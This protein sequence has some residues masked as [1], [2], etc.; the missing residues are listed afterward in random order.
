MSHVK[1]SGSEYNRDVMEIIED[2]NNAQEIVEVLSYD[3]DIELIRSTI[4]GLIE[5]IINQV[6]SEMPDSLD[7][8]QSMP[9]SMPQG[10]KDAQKINTE[11]DFWFDYM[12]QHQML[13]HLNALLHSPSKFQEFLQTNPEVLDISVAKKS[14]VKKDDKTLKDEDAVQLHF[15][16]PKIIITHHKENIKKIVRAV[17]EKLQLLLNNS[18]KEGLSLLMFGKVQQQKGLAGRNNILIKEGAED[19]LQVYV[20]ERVHTFLNQMIFKKLP[21]Y[22]KPLTEG[23]CNYLSVYLLETI[24]F[25]KS[26]SS[27]GNLDKDL[28]SIQEGEQKEDKEHNEKLLKMIIDKIDPQKKEGDR[29]ILDIRQKI[30]NDSDMSSLLLTKMQ[31]KNIDNVTALKELWDEID[32]NK[33]ELSYNIRALKELWDETDNNK[34]K[35]NANIEDLKKIWKKID[36]NKKEPNEHNESL[37]E[38]EAVIDISKKKLN[39]NIDDLKEEFFTIDEATM[40]E[41]HKLSLYDYEFGQTLV[42]VFIDQYPSLIEAMPKF[43]E[44]YCMFYSP[45]YTRYGTIEKF[46]KGM[47]KLGYSNAFINKILTSTADR[48]LLKSLKGER[49]MDYFMKFDL[50]EL[51][52]ILQNQELHVVF[53]ISKNDTILLERNISLMNNYLKRHYSKYSHRQ[54]IKQYFQEKLINQLKYL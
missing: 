21:F 13:K 40:K 37:K 53:G 51:K 26:Q 52:I 5:D 27:P 30:A 35:I 17:D 9:Q 47:S 24:V 15:I 43:L 16:L 32:D 7:E 12:D 54:Y 34:K 2:E 4:K 48:L 29:P 10:Y 41:K 36:M 22:Y 33:K 3:P 11:L 44:L 23:I 6:T 25:E 1:S 19:F 45:E 49:L 31:N 42:E 50:K 46:E 14:M 38:R 8:F 39:D 20:H 28:S 18:G